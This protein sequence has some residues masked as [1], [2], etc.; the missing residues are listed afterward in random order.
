M[1]HKIRKTANSDV[2]N[3]IKLLKIRRFCKNPGGCLAFG[4]IKMYTT[5]IWIKFKGFSSLPLPYHEETSS[6]FVCG[7]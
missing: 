5:L 3:Q 1:N 6:V 7:M 4:K 2:Q